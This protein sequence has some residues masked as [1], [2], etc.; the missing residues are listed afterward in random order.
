VKR[1]E[2]ITLLGGAAAAWPLAV[3]AQQQAMPVIGFLSSAFS[4]RDAGRLDAYRRGL[5]E[6]GYVEGRNV[7]I[8]YRWADE[9]LERLPTLAADLVGR[10]VAV[11]ATS[12]HVRG[13]LAAKA[14]T[15]SIPIVFLTGSDPVAIGL[16]ASLNRPGGNVTGVATL[17]L[18]LEQ[19]RLELL[20]EVAPA[21]TTVAALINPNHPYAGIQSSDL[22]MAARKLGLKI[23]IINASIESDFEATFTRLAGLHAGG[24]VIAT[25]GIFISRSERLAA[26]AFQHAVPA[27]FQFRS[28]AAAGGLM[29]YGGSMAELYRECG[30]YTARILNGEKPADLPVQQV[31]KVELIINMKTAKALGL[32]VP[33]SLL[34]RAD[35]VIE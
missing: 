8:E 3:R 14:A 4:D 21:T 10:E 20:H 33:L 9:Q 25:D 35:E 26:L 32:T 11:I 19:K 16:V 2:V 12:G 29:S 24:L 6:A 15:Q 13:A 23:H 28:F 22:Q 17:S 31:T 18:E 7:A 5:A 34:G 1:R 27:I 30:I